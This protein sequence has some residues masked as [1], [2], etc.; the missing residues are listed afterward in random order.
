MKGQVINRPLLNS[1]NAI[2]DYVRAAM[3]F[4]DIESFRILFLDKKNS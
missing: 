4:Q 1:W 2:L 3:A